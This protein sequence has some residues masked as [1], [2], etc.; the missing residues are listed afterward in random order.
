[1]QEK[2]INKVFEEFNSVSNGVK[3]TLN[4]FFTVLKLFLNCISLFGY[5]SYMTITHVFY[6]RENELKTLMYTKIHAI[7]NKLD[8]KLIKWHL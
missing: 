7:L 8:I 1:M 5:F 3:N 4:L 6:M 2:Y